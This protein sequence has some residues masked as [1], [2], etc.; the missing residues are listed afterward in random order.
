MTSKI[1]ILGQNFGPL[2]GSFWPISGSKNPFSGLFKVVL[3][4]FRSCLS[5]IFGFKRPTF[6]VFSARKGVNIILTQKRF[7]PLGSRGS[8]INLHTRLPSATSYN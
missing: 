2:R 8:P 6:C 5:I 1:E 3:E 4:L 7:S